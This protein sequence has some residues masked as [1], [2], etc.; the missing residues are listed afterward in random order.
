M[1]A[2]LRALREGAADV[3]PLAEHFIRVYGESYNATA[4]L[5]REAKQA[6]VST[7]GPVTSGSWSAWIAEFPRRLVVRHKV[8]P[9]SVPTFRARDTLH[10]RVVRYPLH[11]RYAVRG[12]LA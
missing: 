9:V 11:H 3:L 10:A 7:R 1:Y 6:L 4:D 8:P 12:E 5:D 2:R